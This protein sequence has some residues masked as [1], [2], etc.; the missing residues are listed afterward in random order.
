MNS[1]LLQLTRLRQGFGVQAIENYL[2]IPKVRSEKVN[3][4]RKLKRA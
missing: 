4:K 2:N 1:L 3:S